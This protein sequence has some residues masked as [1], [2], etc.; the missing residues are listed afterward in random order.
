MVVEFLEF[1]IKSGSILAISVLVYVLVLS[2]DIFFKLN[3]LWLIGSLI[4][5]WIIPLLTM[6][7]W[8]KELLFTS[9][10]TAVQ[11]STSI[12][13]YAMGQAPVTISSQNSFS[14]EMLGL[15]LY[16]F[17]SFIFLI[18]L[19]WGYSSIIQLKRQ[20]NHKTY[21]GLSLAVFSDVTQV[22]SH[23][24]APFIYLKKWKKEVT[25]I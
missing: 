21:K 6:P 9:G 13:N 5:P 11:F 15:A 25:K 10:E 14:W 8:I 1:L 20:S 2:N 23:F 17:V 3:R 7:V 18:R 12:L 24:S 22:H 16:S 4:L 19:M